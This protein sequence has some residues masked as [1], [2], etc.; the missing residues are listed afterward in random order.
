MDST[1]AWILA[2]G[3]GAM[4]AIKHQGQ[5]FSGSVQ[6]QAKNYKVSAVSQAKKKEKKLPSSAIV[7][8]ILT[9]DKPHQISH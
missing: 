6:N 2:A 3:I 5:S 9:Q 7:S 4:E 8:T 1:R